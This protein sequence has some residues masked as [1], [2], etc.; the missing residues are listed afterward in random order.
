MQV[1]Q[2]EGDYGDPPGGDMEHPDHGGVVASHRGQG[3]YKGLALDL[4]A[5][6]AIWFLPMTKKSLALYQ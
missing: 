3:H 6:S 4:G 5:N 2:E 1:D